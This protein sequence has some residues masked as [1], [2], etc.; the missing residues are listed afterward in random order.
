MLLNIYFSYM[1]YLNF[2]LNEGKNKNFN[3]KLYAMRIYVCYS[4][5]FAA[6][7]IMEIKLNENAYGKRQFYDDC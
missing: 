2:E 1:E 3:L 4:S 6:I 7:N 5:H